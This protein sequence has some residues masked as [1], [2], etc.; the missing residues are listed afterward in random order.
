MI[1]PQPIVLVGF[2]LRLEPLDLHHEQAL[3]EAACDGELWNLRVTSVPEPTKVRAYIETAQA[4]C[5]AGHR[6]AWAVIDQTSNRLLGSSSYHDILRDVDRVEI[7]YTWYRK[8]VQRS[9]VNTAC[10]LLLMQHAFD[11]LGCKVVGWRTDIFNFASQRAIEKLGASRDGVVQHN[12]LRR[13]GTV[14]D[15]VMYSLLRADWPTVKVQLTARMARLQTNPVFNVPRAIELVSID[16]SNVNAI[17]RLKPG[18][19]GSNMVAANGSS[20]A[21]AQFSKNA[22]QFGV[23]LRAQENQE[24]KLIGYLLLWDPTVF[25]QTKEP[26]NRLY[27]WRLMIDFQF[28]GLGYGAQV[29]RKVQAMAQTL[30]GIT[31]VTLSRSLLEQNPA[32]FYKKMGFNETGVIEDG[33]AEMIWKV[34]V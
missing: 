16:E 11:T 19:N 17:L 14:R 18:A 29:M 28:Q 10:K 13:D 1:D 22:R 2:G 12:A 9:S 34:P 15:T 30:P 27:V 21:Q 6:I 24:A 3:R 7:G 5:A 26:Q 31:E 32:P 4:G 20:I 33:E 25:A 8:S 23:Q